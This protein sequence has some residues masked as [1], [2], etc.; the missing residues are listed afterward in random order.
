MVLHNLLSLSN[1]RDA[2]CMSE[3]DPLCTRVSAS[4]SLRT[5]VLVLLLAARRVLPYSALSFLA[6]STSLASKIAFAL[7]YRV[8]VLIARYLRIRVTGIFR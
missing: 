6:F 8:A 3:R 5:Q 4:L 2:C 7:D 1:L